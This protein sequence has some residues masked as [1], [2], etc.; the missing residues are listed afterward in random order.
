MQKLKINASWN[1]IIKKVEEIEDIRLLPYKHFQVYLNSNSCMIQ[2]LNFRSSKPIKDSFFFTETLNTKKES[3]I[4]VC[5][6]FINWFNN[7]K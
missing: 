5:N 1:T 6:V 3:T 7:L 2:S 4:Y